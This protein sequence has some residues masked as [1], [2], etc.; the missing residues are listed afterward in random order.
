ML[1]RY[2]IYSPSWSALNAV[3]YIS[4]RQKSNLQTKCSL[5]RRVF[6]FAK[7]KQL[8]YIFLSAVKHGAAA[9]VYQL[10]RNRFSHSDFIFEK[11]KNA[12][13]IIK[14]VYPV[15][16]KK[17]RYLLT[18]QSSIVYIGYLFRYDFDYK[19]FTSRRRDSHMSGL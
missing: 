2:Y 1:H 15:K 8:N 16:E 7:I 13:K 9:S 12:R 11:K 3:K 4:T 18:R 5:D 19:R 17:N 6:L 14:S 10:N